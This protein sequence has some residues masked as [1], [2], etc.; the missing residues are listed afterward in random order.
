MSGER[1]FVSICVPS[2]GS[3]KPKTA[4]HTIALAMK[5]LC[6]G[7]AV[8]PM[9][10][11]QAPIAEARNQLVRNS[12]A[13]NV[14]H[15]FMLDSD[16]VVPDDAIVRLLKRDKP[17]IGATARRRLPPYQL[18]GKWGPPLPGVDPDLR[19]ATHLGAAALLIRVEVFRATRPPWFF[20]TYAGEQ[21]VG[22]DIN[23]LHY[24]RDFGFEAWVDLALSRDVIHLGEI[25]VKYAMET[26]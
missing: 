7:A 13:L 1:P 6:A 21:R 24:A 16:M 15:I 20:E 22:E 19:Q 12:L 14:S 3:W 26:T 8:V 10:E 17:I 4:V 11:D 5:T 23:F 2:T 9:G 18:L 25:E